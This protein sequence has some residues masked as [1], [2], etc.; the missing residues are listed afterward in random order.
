MSLQ[1]ARLGKGIGGHHSARSRTD[2]WLTPPKILAAL[3]EFD[4]DP[5][6]AT[7]QPW[8]TARHHFV[9]ADNGLM[10]PWVGRVWLNPPYGKEAAAWL[11]RLAQHGDGI[12]LIF[13]RT[14][15]QMFF[16]SVWPKASAL[17]FIRGRLNF[18]LPNGERATKNA[19]G[20]TVLA[21][22][23][24]RNA[25]ALELSGIPGAFIR[26]VGVQL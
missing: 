25:N 9:E 18:H 4:L 1:E 20:P 22:Y 21:A 14:E 10:Q 8:K 2:V 12:A 19:G 7:G 23:G 26:L 6:A 17:L 5:C 15:T 3:G 16:A 13:A 24:A 11:D